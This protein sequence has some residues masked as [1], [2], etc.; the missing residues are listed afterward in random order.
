MIRKIMLAGILALSGCMDTVTGTP[1][2]S[3]ATKPTYFIAEQ[4]GPSCTR[5]NRGGR[6]SVASAER[7]LTALRVN[8]ERYISDLRQSTS[9][10]VKFD[11]FR[12]HWQP[13]LFN[14]YAAAAANDV[15]LARTII[16]GLRQMAIEGRYTN[17][18]SLITRPQ[19]IQLTDCYAN[20]PNSPCAQF[21]PMFV[22][23][24]YALLM[25]STAVLEPHVTDEDRE[26]L[27]PWFDRAYR[28][29]VV[30]AVEMD[31]EG[32]Y[33]LGNMGMARLAYAA[34]TNDMRL[35]DR[36]LRT[37]RAEFI[38]RFETSGYI[39]RNS[40]RGVRGFWY[41]TYGVD[42]ALSYALVAREWGYDFFAD[43]TLGPRFRAAVDKTTL[44]INDLQAFRSVGNR[45]NNITTNPA[46][47][48]PHVMQLALNLYEISEREFG[49]RLPPDRRYQ[50]IARFEQYPAIS[51]MAASCYYSG[52]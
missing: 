4:L 31:Q 30:D 10:T 41:H 28:R 15:E 16:D 26:V 40:Y 18:P 5:D 24:M 45:G 12:V 47:A 52:R 48:R 19:A 34:L 3:R 21:T 36:E 43:E 22:A 50:Q 7:A 17:E 23:R 49:V 44:G 29:F 9:M 1:D 33:D 6:A 13:V 39:Y 38:R 42:V 35:A 46:D 8:S 27:M 14:S 20:G 37:R 51:G 32:I 11:D 25:I 2:V